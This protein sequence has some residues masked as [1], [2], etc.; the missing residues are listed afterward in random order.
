ARAVIDNP[1]SNIGKA[2]VAAAPKLTR[3]ATQDAS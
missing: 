3:K 2:L 1:H